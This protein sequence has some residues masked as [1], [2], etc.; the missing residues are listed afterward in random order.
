[1]HERR[2]YCLGGARRAQVFMRPFCGIEAN[3]G[4]LQPL[5]KLAG[6]TPADKRAG[7]RIALVTQVG[8]AKEDER[9]NIPQATLRKIG[10][11]LLAFRSERIQPGVNQ[12]ER[13]PTPYQQRQ[14]MD[15]PPELV[16][17]A[18]RAGY[19]GFALDR[20]DRER[21]KNFYRSNALT[22]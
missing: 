21:S 16:V 11:N 22:S 13:A 19:N 6:L 17:M 20:C 18:G 12:E 10:A 7:W 5:E 4:R 8:T 15:V 2:N 1:M 14:E 9:V 3:K